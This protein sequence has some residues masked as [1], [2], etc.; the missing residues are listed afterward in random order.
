MQNNFCTDGDYLGYCYIAEK[1]EG[2]NIKNVISGKD[3][4]TGQPF[5]TYDQVLQSFDVENRNKRFYDGDNIWQCIMTE[6]IQS[7]LLHNGWFMELDHPLCK[8]ANMKLSPERVRNIEYRERCAVIKK[9]RREGNLLIGTITTTGNDLGV[10]LCNDIIGPVGYMPMASCRAIACMTTRN[11]KPYVFVKK[12]ITYDTV[13]FAS[14]READVVGAPVL[15]QKTMKVTESVNDK[16]TDDKYDMVVPLTD[17]L[18]QVGEHD[19]STNFVLESFGLTDENI[20]G[21][22]ED[23]THSI[24]QQEDNK[25]YVAM[26]PDTVKMVN[27]YFDNF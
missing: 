13:S 20:V 5:A 10:Q 4:L 17:I 18:D 23:H 9:P 19:A 22:S 8:Y 12:L 14:H 7:K 2:Y 6:E 26:R 25:I 1:T 24:I 15:M 3:A 21:I 16:E 11:G 27:S